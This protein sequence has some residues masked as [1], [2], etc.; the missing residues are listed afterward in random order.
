MLAHVVSFYMHLLIFDSTSSFV[1]QMQFHLL[2]PLL[3]EQ[4]VGDRSWWPHQIIHGGDVVCL[5]ISYEVTPKRITSSSFFVQIRFCTQQDAGFT[6]AFF[7]AN[8]AG[9]SLR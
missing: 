9:D 7:H 1:P 3:V 4:H 8:G 2:S 6:F 5:A